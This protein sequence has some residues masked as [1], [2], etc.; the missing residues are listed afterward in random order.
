MRLLEKEEE[1][2]K[3][4]KKNMM[5]KSVVRVLVISIVIR[6]ISA[7]GAADAIIQPP[8]FHPDAEYQLA[9]T[10]AFIHR[11]CFHRHDDQ[12]PIVHVAGDN[13]GDLITFADGST[14]QVPPCPFTL[15]PLSHQYYR[16]IN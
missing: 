6:E 14:K 1:R 15:R 3:S 5:F 2:K 13:S 7:A 8:L 9:P 10:G 16:Y 4:E 11:D 12:N